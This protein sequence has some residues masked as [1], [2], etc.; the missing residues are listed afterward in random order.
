[1]RYTKEDRP[2]V[3]SIPVYRPEKTGKANFSLEMRANCS[4]VY[5]KWR[6]PCTMTIHTVVSLSNQLESGVYGLFPWCRQSSTKY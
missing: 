5:P 4:H 6:M 3:F 1:M 2:Y